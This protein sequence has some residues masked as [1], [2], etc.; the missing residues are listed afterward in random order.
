MSAEFYAA[1]EITRTDNDVFSS[2]NKN[3]IEEY[4]RCKVF[5]GYWTNFDCDIIEVNDKNMTIKISD[6]Y[7]DDESGVDWDDQSDEYRENEEPLAKKFAEEFN[8]NFIEYH[9]SVSFF[10]C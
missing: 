10:G 8:K 1:L 9:A 2:E 3:Q 5:L 7:L 6:Q 4:F